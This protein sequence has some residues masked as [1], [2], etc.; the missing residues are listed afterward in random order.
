MVTLIILANFIFSNLTYKGRLEIIFQIF[1]EMN[2]TETVPFVQ[3]I[4]HGV[5]LGNNNYC[6]HFV[7]KGIKLYCFSHKCFCFAVVNFTRL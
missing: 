3:S 7:Q 6:T 5:L 1:N 4:V 2:L